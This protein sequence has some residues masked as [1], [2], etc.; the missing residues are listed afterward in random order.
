MVTVPVKHI[1]LALLVFSVY[2]A[3]VRNEIILIHTLV[4]RQCYLTD[5]YINGYLLLFSTDLH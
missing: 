2:I 4:G 5:Q 1:E 3:G